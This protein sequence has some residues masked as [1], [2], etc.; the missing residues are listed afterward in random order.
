MDPTVAV[1]V[2]VPSAVVQSEI[3]GALEGGCLEQSLMLQKNGPELSGQVM[4]WTIS[5][6]SR[7]WDVEVVV[8]GSKIPSL[9]GQK[10]S[11][12]YFYQFGGFG[13]TRRELSVATLQSPSHGV[14][15][16]EGS[17]LP[18]LGKLPL[19]LSRGS[20]TCTVN[21]QCGSY[22]R[23]DLG[24]FDPL[25]MVTV[26][27]VHSQT[28]A[29]GPWV[30]VHGGYEEQTSMGSMCNDWFVADVHVAILGLM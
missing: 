14:W 16:A 9:G 28:A 29:F 2:S 27:L 17:D 20:A 30:L 3:V 21:E 7:L 5:D 1:K 25:T 19:V 4:S 18:Y 12:N 13:P 22:E 24:A 15:T 23:Y 8:E 6:G 26:S 11:L 10:V